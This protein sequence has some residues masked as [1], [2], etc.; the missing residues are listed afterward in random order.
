[1]FYRKWRGYHLF[2]T[3]LSKYVLIPEILSLFLSFDISDPHYKSVQQKNLILIDF[4]HLFSLE[5]VI[6]GWKSC[7]V[8]SM[9]PG[10]WCLLWALS[11]FAFIPLLG[12]RNL[13]SSVV[14][15][16][17]RI[18]QD[19]RHQQSYLL[20]PVYFVPRATNVK[21]APLNQTE[22]GYIFFKSERTIGYLSLLTQNL[23]EPK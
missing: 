5:S 23:F 6:V 8:Y 12:S 15:N 7:K 18:L 17:I 20:D 11:T 3:C 10:D 16:R 19:P 4:L 22:S 2:L 1:M 9:F 13:Y 14:A 21:S